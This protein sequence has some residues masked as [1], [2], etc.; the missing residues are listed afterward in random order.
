MKRIIS[1]I[2]LSAGCLAGFA[3]EE[4]PAA[5]KQALASFMNEVVVS[6]EV[7]GIV[8]L[9]G[10][11]DRILSFDAA[12]L[13]DIEAKRPMKK[14]SMVWIASM[15]KPV[16]GTAV[17]M[18]AD[19]GLLALTDPVAKYL[20]EFKD[21]KDAEGKEI[22]ITI[23]NCLAH[24]AGLQE[25][26]PEEELATSNLDQL[27]KITAK[28]PVKFAPG[29]KWTYCQTGISV[30][31]RIV[32]VV[33]GETF[34][35][36]LQKRLFTP[37]G[38]N[39]TTFYMPEE[40]MDRLALSYEKTPDG[41]MKE[42][43]PYF[44]NGR[45]PTDRSRYPR[46]SGG[47]F[48]TAEDYSKFLRM[49]LRGGEADGKRYL[50]PET[51]AEMTRGHTGTLEK[52][53]FVPGNAYALGWIRVLDPQGVTAPL[54]SGSFGH[55]GAYGTQAWIDPVKGRYTIMMIQR[56][57]IGNGDGSP[58]RGKFQEAAAK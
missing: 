35:D 26:T 5:L 53:G 39:D 1:A 33:S 30:A 55:G 14:D 48:S 47:L 36:F 32:E 24:T 25:L 56:A 23:E 2:M 57:K 15:T 51:I 29:S 11:K 28:K 22:M 4:S 18:L 31:A 3:K 41:L 49:I 50:K 37:L 8:T 38:M 19:E 44:L 40:K 17:M 45:S 20:P 43:E 7:P 52:V 34:P 13:A 16:T 12:G 6:N 54:S 27:S 21:L 10:D 42:V 9:V 58:I 46:A